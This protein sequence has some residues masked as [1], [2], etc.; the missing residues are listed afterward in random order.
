MHG[1]DPS[2]G[3]VLQDTSFTLPPLQGHNLDEHFYR[4]GAAASEPWLKIAKELSRAQLHPR[5]DDWNIQSG[6]TKYVYEPNGGS[7]HITVPYPENDGQPEQMLVFDV[8]TMPEYSPYPVMATAVS[9]NGWYSWISPWLLGETED[10][11]HL[12][13]IGDRTVPRVIVGHN[14]SYDRGRILEEYNIEQ[15]ETRFLDT[16]ALHVAVKGISSHQRPAWNKYR[17]SKEMVQNQKAE[18][19]D[20][21]LAMMQELEDARQAETDPDEK[22]NLSRLLRDLT[23]SFPQLQEGDIVEP[24]D[25]E[26]TVKRWEELTSANSLADVAKLHCDITMDKDIRNDFMKLTREEIAEG[27]RDY[28]N[29]CATDVS[30]THAVFSKTLPAFLSACPNPVSFAGVL[31]MGSSLLTVN[32]EWDA[33]LANAERTYKELEDKVKKRLHDL[34]QEAKEMVQTGEWQSDVWLSQMDWTP[35]VVKESRGVVSVKVGSFMNVLSMKGSLN[36]TR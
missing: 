9:Q 11:R 12:I 29:Y 19:V 2:Q 16:M 30:V 4:I 7:Y 25:D 34:A 33:Y 32:E 20:A 17:K 27:I 23:E 10:V 6:W 35:K 36:Q 21:V 14:V 1:L 28:L 15:T 3:S 24:D 8:E 13:P 26:L 22:E 5:P 31:T 18:S